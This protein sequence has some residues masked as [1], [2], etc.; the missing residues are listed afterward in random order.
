MKQFTVN[1]ELCTQCGACAKDCPVGVIK[2]DE[3]PV[4]EK[5]GCFECQ[6]CLAV[7]PTAALSI[8]GRDPADSTPLKGNLPSP[9]QMTTLIKGRR[10]VRQYKDE[11]LEPEQL[12]QLLDTAWH[13]PTGVNVQS[14]QFTVISD[15]ENMNK[16]RDEVY[17]K[18]E[19]I[20]PEEAPAG[21]HVLQFLIWGVQGRKKY[22]TDMIFR[23]APH[24]IVTSS[25]KSAPCGNADS[26]I[27]L[28]YFELLAQSMGIG[29]VWNGMIKD[30]LHKIPE[31]ST[32]LGIPDDHQLGYVMAFGK[33][34]VRYHRTA[35][36]GPAN[37]TTV[38]WA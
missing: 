31:L 22:G 30:A 7:C 11:D 34:A 8:L 13:A 6:Q 12:Q 18:L 4:M 28:S 15:R 21:D 25:P 2:M 3:F 20:L 5:K 38:K 37:V 14:V 9:Q 16:F 29:T 36:R 19:E 35:Q 26:H 1:K 32:R 23:G 24:M 27:A 33:P 17:A 10:S